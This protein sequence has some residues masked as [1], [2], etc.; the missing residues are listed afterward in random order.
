MAIAV[1]GY[2]QMV[3]PRARVRPEKRKVAVLDIDYHHGNGTSKVFYTDPTVL[4]VSLHGSPDYPYYTGGE[5]ERGSGAG[6]GANLNFP[7]PL[8]TDDESYL[9]TLKTAVEHIRSFEADFLF[10]S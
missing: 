9:R 3:L 2:Q 8:G 6:V 4:Y 1:K 7:L 10:V 5:N